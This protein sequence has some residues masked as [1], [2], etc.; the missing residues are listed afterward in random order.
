[1]TV[2]DYKRGHAQAQI[3]AATFK[4]CN[5]K[6]LILSAEDV[7]DLDDNESIIGQSLKL[8]IRDNNYGEEELFVELD[9]NDGVDLV[10]ILQR[11]LRQISSS[12]IETR[13]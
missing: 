9:V 4:L 11:L 6:S 7:Y 8:L 13:R 5:E 2:I 10:K 3:E 12:A 1:M